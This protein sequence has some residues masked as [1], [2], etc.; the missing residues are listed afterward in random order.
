MAFIGFEGELI[1][2][3]APITGDPYYADVFDE[4]FDFQISFAETIAENGDAF[5][6]LTEEESY[7]K[8]YDALSE[9]AHEA[10]YILVS[11]VSDIWARDFSLSNV[12]SPVMFRYTSAGQGGE[13]G[14]GQSDSD[15]VQ[16][17]FREL[18][19]NSGVNFYESELLNDG[20]NFVDDYNGRAVLSRKFLRDNDMTEDE[21]RRAL[22]D[23]VGI[24]HVS[25]I[26]SDEQGGLEHSDGVVSFVE[27]NVLIMNIYPE[28]LEYENNLKADL[29]AGIPDV[30]IHSIITAYDGSN[31]YDERFG[32][33]FGL[34]TNALV[35]PSRIYFPQFG[36]PED[37]TAL[38]QVSEVTSKTIIPVLSSGV[39]HLGGGVRCMSFQTRGC[40]AD[41]LLEYAEAQNRVTV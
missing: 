19:E 1:V 35:T 22:Q 31:V 18:L 23:E 2:L 11:P 3:S 15:A 33:A 41:A 25:F 12:N 13:R 40:N 20:G 16:G 8:Y 27:P 38:E 6:I 4:I 5:I 9:T 10:G 26:E 14:G 7:S 37:E 39:S 36:I 28:D 24:E 30:E 32:S 34:Y 17:E 21:A 29:E